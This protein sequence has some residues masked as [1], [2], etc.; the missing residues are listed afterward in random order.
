LRSI[1]EALVSVI[2]GFILGLTFCALVGE[3]PLEVM[4][5]LTT[6][7]FGSRY[8]FGMTLSYTVPLIFTGLSVAV[9]YR[10]GLFNIGAEGQLIWGA[11]AAAFVGIRFPSLGGLSALLAGLIAGFCGGAIWGALAGLLKAYRGSHEVISTIMLNFIAAGI[12]GYLAL[13]P[14]KDP[15]SQNP[16]TAPVGA[17]YL[18][19]HFQVFQGAP[20]THALWISVV[21]AVVLWII[22][23]R[24]VFG[25]HLRAIGENEIAASTYG[26]RGK[27]LQV[28]AMALA[29]GCAG[30]VG[31]SEVLGNSGCFKI[32]FSPGY[33]FTGIAVALL[34]RGNP[35]A[36][37]FSAF[38]FGALNKGASDL[39]LE[40]ERMTRDLAMIFQALVILSVSTVSILNIFRKKQ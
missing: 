28:W 10:A 30:L 29:G 5:V 37:V 31:F 32:G 24:S 27:R 35:I 17:E 16:Q 3:S 34:A 9:A 23:E 25:Y 22:F 12:T 2:L 13:Y 38:L 20:V 1:I 7:A 8:D 19:T 21:S 6:G 39:D 33:G 36:I 4:R 18:L 40:T 14:F 15:G 26:V 11:F